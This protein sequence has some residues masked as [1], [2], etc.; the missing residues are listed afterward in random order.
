MDNPRATGGILSD[1]DYRDAIAT[2]AVLAAAIDTMLADAALPE[3]FKID[4]ENLK[5]L[6]Q[7]KIPACVS[8]GWALVMKYWWWKKT[9]E[10]VD[11]S[12]RF[13]DIMSSEDWIPLDGGRAPRTVCKVSMNIG[14]C[15]TALLPNDT[16]GLSI[17]EYRNKNVITQAMLDEA[18]KYRIPGY[19]KIPDEKIEDFRK[20]TKLYG[21]VS[22]LFAISDA[23]WVPSWNSNDIDPLRT[24]QSTSNHQMVVYGW[25]GAMNL[26]RN[27]WSALWNKQGNAT[28]NAKQWLDFIYEGWAIATI[29]E[30]TAAFLKSLPKPYEFTYRWNRN[31]TLGETS[32]DVKFAQIAF[33]ILG[34]LKPI[35]PD[36]LGIFGPKTAKANML[37]QAASKITPTAP[38]NIGPKTRAAL[39]TRFGL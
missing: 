28:Y 36:E 6:D 35:T 38:N 24:K 21:L 30:D 14:C 15:T 1:P 11:F 10:I 39:N 13:L 20:A 29:P 26:L 37:F 3:S 27:S 12:P 5:V 2:N 17:A 18:K 4:I 22:A 33:M 32:E 19:I 25:D 16:E 7:N 9:G 34:Y 23:F 31:L 8:H